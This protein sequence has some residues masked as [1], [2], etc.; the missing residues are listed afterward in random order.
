MNVLFLLKS[1]FLLG[2]K[3]MLTFSWELGKFWKMYNLLVT[4][5]FQNFDWIVDIFERSSIIIHKWNA[6][7]FKVL[8]SF[9]RRRFHMNEIYAC[10]G[11]DN[12]LILESV[13]STFLNF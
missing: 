1:L 12:Q 2:L 7:T 4:T 13:R 10:F 9:L 11:V 8:H 6:S 5:Y 3:L